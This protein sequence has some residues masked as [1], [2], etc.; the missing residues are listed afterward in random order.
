MFAGSASS[1]SAF[2]DG[3]GSD[4]RFSDVYGTAIDSSENIYIADNSYGKIRKI[5]PNGVVSTIVGTANNTPKDGDATSAKLFYPWGIAMD[6]RGNIYFTETYSNLVRKVDSS[7]NVQ[8]IVGTYSNTKAT[9][10]NVATFNTFNGIAYDSSTDALYFTSSRNR[11]IFQYSKE[12]SVSVYAGSQYGKYGSDDGLGTNARFNYPN[13]VTVDSQGNIY[14]VDYNNAL[15]RLVDTQGNVM[16]IAGKTGVNSKQDG[17][18]KSD[19]FYTPKSIAYNMN[20]GSIYVADIYGETICQLRPPSSVTSSVTCP[21]L[22]DRYGYMPNISQGNLPAFYKSAAA[23]CT[24]QLFQYWDT[25]YG[26]IPLVTMGSAEYNQKIVASYKFR[27]CNIYVNVG[28]QQCQAIYDSYGYVFN[29]PGPLSGNEKAIASNCKQ[30]ASK[31]ATTTK[32]TTT[33]TFMASTALSASFASSASCKASSSSSISSSS[34]SASSKST[35][36]TASSTSSK[37]ST[38]SSSLSTSKSSASLASTQSSSSTARTTTSYSSTSSETSSSTSFSST[39]FQSSSSSE[40]RYTTAATASPTTS[41]QVNLS[42]S[43]SFNTYIIGGAAAGGAR[44]FGAFA[45]FLSRRAKR[46]SEDID[47]YSDIEER[48]HDNLLYRADYQPARF[49]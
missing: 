34:S 30:F 29:N 14:V 6:N 18:G 13:A 26:I 24:T 2:A 12:G 47:D 37:S 33:S 42:S 46:N 15:V 38:S 32:T 11:I 44:V 4:A 22:Y 1:A 17:V 48:S 36:K 7:G 10:S 8:T 28:V 45:F 41:S 39:T 40:T 31:I 9:M 49:R 19:S 21:N 35:S 27:N 16:T 3:T 23:Q 5:T 20:A 25:K 43:S